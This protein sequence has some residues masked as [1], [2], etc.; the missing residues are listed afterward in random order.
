MKPC[1]IP[2]PRLARATFLLVLAALAGTPTWAALT[3][4]DARTLAESRAPMLAARQAAVDAARALSTSAGELPDPKLSAGVDN[5]PVSGPMR[6]QISADG[7]TQRS[8]A[9][10]QEVPNAAKRA[11]RREGAEARTAREATMLA[12]ERLAVRRE[13]TQAWLMRWYA[14]K[15]LAAFAALID[16]NRL[17]VETL[18]ARVAAGKA[19]PSD[20]TMARQEALMLADRRDELERERAQAQATLARWLGEAA[21]QPLAGEPAALLPDA[22][23]LRE[24]VDRQPE[25][26]AFEPMR[27][28]AASEMREAEAMRR[29]DWAWQVMYSRRNPMFGDMVSFQLTFELPLWG[30]KRQ[31]PQVAARRREMERLEGEREDLRRR[32]REEIDLQLAEIDELDRKLVRLKEQSAPLAE[33][34]VTLALAAYE[35]AR[36][37]LSAVLTARRERAELAL[38]DIELQARRHALRARLADLTE[39]EPR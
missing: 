30:E 23:A 13:V 2:V 16:E 7:M 27:Q 19:M 21:A 3:L 32:R 31:E 9:W 28:M 24:A 11:A 6:W 5:L 10:M 12:A 34:R 33:Q 39:P 38:R 1:E 36:G 25:L 18:P 37:E 4:A 14:E 22:A 26:Q 35:G 17:L 15:R 8:V 29:G 20:L